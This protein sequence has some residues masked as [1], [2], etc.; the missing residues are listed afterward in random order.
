M[1]PTSTP[2]GPDF[3]KQMIG[4]LF[5]SVEKGTLMGVRMVWDIVIT[6]LTAHWLAVLLV[7][8]VILVATTLK[9]MMGHWGSLGSLLYNI[10][11]F[12]TLL[13]IGLIWGPDVFADDYFNAACAVI[14]YPICYWIVGWILRKTGLMR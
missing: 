1:A 12:G 3:P 9:A 14:L 11:Y 10:L 2:L 13:I 5:D 7:I 6:L 4:L 8:F